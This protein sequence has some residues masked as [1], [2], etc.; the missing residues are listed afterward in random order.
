MHLLI[1]GAWQNASDHMDQ[2]R[3]MGHEIVFHPQEWE[4]LPCDPQWAEGVICNGL[5]L[6]HPIE[7]FTRLRY[8][9]LTSAG[10]DRVNLPYIH[11][12]HIELHNARGVY[13]TPM[14]EFALAGVLSLYKRLL[15]FR[16]LQRDHTWKKDRGLIELFGKMVLILGCGSVGTECAVRFKAMG[17]E[18]IGVDIDT[19]TKRGTEYKRIAPLDELDSLFSSA[20]VIILA[21]PVT[22]ETRG[23][24]GTERLASLKETCVVVNIS[25]GAIIDQKALKEWNGMAVLDVFEE[26]PLG[27]DSFL[28]DRENIIITPH[29]S[30]VGEG[31]QKRLAEVI[32]KNLREVSEE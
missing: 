15:H 21:L 24:I 32:M 20:D 6:H 29:N 11:A 17:C 18:V 26:E 25:R 27:E 5:F 16:D 23:L 28:W 4:A 3:A 13:S 2:I 31:N 22:D 10:L 30:F 12:N 7:G 19:K 9:Q 8:I 14:A 1:T